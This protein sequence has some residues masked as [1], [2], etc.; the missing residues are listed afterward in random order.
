M[1]ELRYANWCKLRLN[2]T[3]VQQYKQKLDVYQKTLNSDQINPDLIKQNLVLGDEPNAVANYE[4][5]GN[6]NLSF[7]PNW[8]FNGDYTYLVVGKN[9]SDLRGNFLKVTWSNLKNSS[10]R[11]QKIGKMSAVFS[12][13]IHD[14]NNQQNRDSWL[15]IFKN[16]YKGFWYLVS[17]SLTVEYTLYDESG[18][19]ITLPNDESAWVTIG[20]LNAG[21]GRREG[22]SLLSEGK[23]Y[24]FKDSSITVHNGNSLYSDTANSQTQKIG[25]DWRDIENVTSEYPWGTEDWDRGLADPHAYYGAGVF[26]ISGGHFKIKYFTD[27]THQDNT[28]T[29]AN[30]STSI[31]KSNSGIIPPTIH[32]HR[33][34]VALLLHRKKSVKTLF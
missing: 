29:W 23:A 13:L 12:D 32:Y 3:Q 4:K 31:V 9:L 11:G 1:L 16:P 18:N 15:I 14:N 19:P 22:A 2:N 5:F 27:R 6:S 33:T 34:N 8:N 30:I 17:H 28:D 25:S 21:T 24:G 10:Y 20:S 26:N 7:T